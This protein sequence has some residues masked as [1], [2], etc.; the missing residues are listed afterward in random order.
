[1]TSMAA[2]AAASPSALEWNYRQRHQDA[3]QRP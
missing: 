2:S 1:M 3:A